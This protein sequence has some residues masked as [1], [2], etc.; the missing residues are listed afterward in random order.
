MSDDHLRRKL[1]IVSIVAAGLATVVL[2]LAV[3]LWRGG[4]GSADPSGASRTAAAGKPAT[5][6]VVGQ[7]V[8]REF[9]YELE[10]LGTARANEA[11][12]VTAKTSNLITAIR[13]KEGQAVRRGEVLVELDG[14]QAT[15]DLAQAQAALVESKSQYDRSVE[16]IATKALSQSQLDQI[17][18]T[19]RAN[20]AKVAASASRLGDTIVRAP[21]DGHVGLRRVSVGSLVNP[22]TIMTTLDDTSRIKVD[23]SVPESQVSVVRPGLAIRAATTAYPGRSFDGTVASVDT[24]VDPVS[25]A[26]GVRAIVP[27]GEGLLKPGMF[28]T[29][30]IVES[31][32]DAIVVPEQALLPEEGKQFVYVVVQGKVDKREIRI[33]RRRPGEVEV[34][35]GLAAGENIVSEGADKLRPGM[36]VQ[37]AP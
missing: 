20:E 33:G 12:E 8:R 3:T 9:P 18:A 17:V 30:R 13:F 6:V 32:K 36:S 22:G 29:V 35:E 15:A 2:G 19:L 14:T 24:R 16:L 11:I 25:R 37:A 1:W 34:L 21:F 31:S 10:A 26:F 5:S 4:G 23:F 7:A 28:L 27:N